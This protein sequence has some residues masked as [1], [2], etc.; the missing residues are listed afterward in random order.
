MRWILV[1]SSDGINIGFVGA[2]KAGITLGAYFA[3]KGLN[4]EGYFSRSRSSSLSAAGITAS[5]A[6]S[7]IAEL[8]E[9]CGMIFITTPDGAIKETWDKISAC[10]IKDKIICHTSGAGSSDIF[11]GIKELGGY[12]Y[13]V[14]PMYAFAE[15][16][17]NYCG[18]ENA[19]FTI[20]GDDGRLDVLNDMF[21]AMGNKTIVIDRNSKTLYHLSNVMVS[22]LVLALVG[23][24]CECLEKCGV[25]GTDA[26]DALY[27]LIKCNIENIG[28]KG[29]INSLTG[30][31]ERNDVETVSS[32]LNVCPENYK[33]V[34]KIL[35]R[36]LTDLS[37]KRHPKRNY[38]KLSEL[39]R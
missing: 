36:K 14:H 4:V 12:G 38:S 10:G 9:K 32:H 3:A 13:S 21:S 19:Y 30:P 39:L 22:N 15:K 33:D 29:L 34:Y 17:G 28:S 16:N 35:T 31:A 27:P 24:G 23:I 26:L 2:G 8:V 6:F 25:D 1:K 37:A 20:E 5:M 11:T 18:L 7:G